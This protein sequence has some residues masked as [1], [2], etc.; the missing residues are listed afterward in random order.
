MEFRHRPDSLCRS[1]EGCKPVAIFKGTVLCTK[2]PS[3]TLAMFV[4]H[5]QAGHLH[6]KG[7]KNSW[8]P[9]HGLCTQHRYTV[10]CL[11][12]R[13]VPVAAGQLRTRL[14]FTGRKECSIEVALLVNTPMDYRAWP[15]TSDVRGTSAGTIPAPRRQAK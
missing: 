15:E 1:P 13:I 14:R 2:L 5:Q 8:C 4:E 11:T 9:F 3:L 6:S 10:L 7:E 12:V